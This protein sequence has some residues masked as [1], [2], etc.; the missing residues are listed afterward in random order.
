MSQGVLHGLNFTKAKKMI[1]VWCKKLSAR[2]KIFLS[3]LVFLS[4]AGCAT[5]SLY[6]PNKSYSK[7]EILSHIRYFLIESGKSIYINS[8]LK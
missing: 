8:S 1:V 5:S 7:N 2:Y 3:A 6:A 4:L